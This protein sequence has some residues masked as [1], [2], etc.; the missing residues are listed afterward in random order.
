MAKDFNHVQVV[1]DYDVHIR[2]LI[3]GYEV[4]HQ[5]IHALLKT[6]VPENAHIL[7]VGCGTGY[8][9]GYLLEKFPNWHFT[10]TELSITMLDKAKQYIQS[11]NGSDRVNFILSNV[12]DL[13]VPDH[14]Y[15]AALSILVA[16][17]VTYLDK[18]DFFQAIYARLKPQAIL[19]T[20][21]LIQSSNSDEAITLKHICMANGL[22]EAQADAML[23]RLAD[24]FY[25]WSEQETFQQ[26]KKSGFHTVQRFSQILSYQ[27]FIATK[28]E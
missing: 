16:H 8:E 9:L 11:L 7:I 20:F 12:N 26:L 27:G 13:A 6:Y 25:P 3:P 5:Q 23:K 4:V 28:I 21:D 15:D 22:V 24:D 2:K 1:Q 17:F 18:A 19:L 10:A 14:T